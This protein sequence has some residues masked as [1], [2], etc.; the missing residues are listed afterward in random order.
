MSIDKR[1]VQGKIRELRQMVDAYIRFSR[2][3]GG[4]GMQTYIPLEEKYRGHRG[5]WAIKTAL[6]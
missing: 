2:S 6:L 4:P 1:M 5:G 3:T